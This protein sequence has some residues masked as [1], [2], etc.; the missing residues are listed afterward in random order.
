MRGRL[1]LIAAS[2]LAAACRGALNPEAC[3]NNPDGWCGEGMY[4][5]RMGDQSKC[6]PVGD[7]SVD[8]KDGGGDSTEVPEDTRDAIS[9]PS[10]AQTDLATA[11]S[12]G[13]GV[14]TPPEECDLGAALN[15]GAYGGCTAT[16]KRAERCGDNAKNGPE[17]C[18]QGPANKVG[19]YGRGLCTADCKNAPYCG[20]TS[21]NGVEICDNGGTG[22]TDLGACNPECS[23]FYEK[24]VIKPTSQHYS[25]NLG[26]PAGADSICQSEF[27][28]G[29]KALLVGGSRRATLTPFKGDAPQDWVIRK[30][31]YYY[32]ASNQLL[33]RTDD[34][35]LLGVHDGKREAIYADV[36]P[37]ASYPWTGWNS[38]W[39]TRSDDANGGTCGG[40]TNATTGWASF[41][42]PDLTFAANEGC[43]SSSFI[44]CA[45]Q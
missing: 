28:S 14:T 41:A 8:H 10:D 25:T 17:E 45:Q 19:A 39:T 5:L 31:T 21:R 12:C 43:G 35:P 2:L 29:W 33:W 18:D 32:N 37:A 4:C 42:F 44:L 22:T 36:F 7:G 11:P 40:W 13:D 15:N 20:D 9:G 24:K 26:G 16:C 34:V 3:A 23:G 27:G 38:D 30:Y 1:G 6:A